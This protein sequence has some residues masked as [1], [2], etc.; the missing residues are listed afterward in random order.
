MDK[1]THTVFLLSLR[2][3]DR[4]RATQSSAVPQQRSSRSNVTLLSSA[5][6]NSLCRKDNRRNDDAT[7]TAAT[8]NSHALLQQPWRSKPRCSTAMFDSS[9]R[10][11]CSTVPRWQVSAIALA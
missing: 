7:T 8:T 10:Q 2:N 3:H 5:T 4:N 1:H 11:F 9:V 6:I